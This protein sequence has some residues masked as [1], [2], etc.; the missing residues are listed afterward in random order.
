[1]ASSILPKGAYIDKKV[2]EGK[3]REREKKQ[4]YHENPVVRR[5]IFPAFFFFQMCT[6]QPVLPS[7][8]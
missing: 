7:L 2:L 1:M 6:K 4:F 5:D 8:F 3:E